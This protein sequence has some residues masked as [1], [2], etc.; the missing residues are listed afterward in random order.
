MD[1]FNEFVELAF[2][3]DKLADIYEGQ[4]NFGLVLKL[5]EDYTTTM[6]GIRSALID[7]ED[8]RQIPL[9]QLADVVSVSG[10][11]SISRENVQR[12]I[13][14]SANV[15]GRDLRSVVE[16]IRQRVGSEIVLPEGYRLEYGGQFESEAKASSTLLWTSLLAIIVIFVRD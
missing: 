2:G 11:S 1:H 5:D 6:D 12:K 3:N 15:A 7:T 14:V 13:V 4:R 16:D 10:P 8:G 9:G